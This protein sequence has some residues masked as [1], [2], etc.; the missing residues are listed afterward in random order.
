MKQFRQT[1]LLLTA[2]IVVACTAPT[3]GGDQVVINAE[4]TL[5][6]SKDTLDLFVSLEYHNQAQVK[7]RFP[8]IHEFAE[9]VRRTA[10]ALLKTAN[11]AKNAYKYN[12]NG[13][14]A[15]QL[16]AAMAAVTKLAA[17]AQTY[18]AQVNVTASAPP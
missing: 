5:R 3:I 17:D 12:R 16:W 1:S 11:D 7:A 10:P 8:A 6:I 18:L 2:F 9:K 13:T 4:K 15:G 14:T